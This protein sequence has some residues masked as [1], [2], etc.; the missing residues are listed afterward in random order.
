MSIT[1]S[2]LEFRRL[3]TKLKE[4]VYD[5]N[6]A[7]G[8][9]PPDTKEKILGY[10]KNANRKTISVNTL[11]RTSGKVKAYLQSQHKK[12]D[13]FH[14]SNLYALTKREEKGD[15]LELKDIY[16]KVYFLLFKDCNDHKDFFTLHPTL[17]P[18]IN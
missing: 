6:I 7:A 4:L 13:D 17:H 10:K 9:R 12:I 1:L 16:E 14:I 11:I 3:Y 5:A 15:P 18:D 2:A 8:N